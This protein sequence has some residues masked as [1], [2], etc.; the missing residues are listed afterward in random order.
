MIKNY[1]KRDV[2]ERILEWIERPEVIFIKGPRQSG[3]TTL[4]EILK[5]KLKDK[6]IYYFS[7]ED[8]N[9]LEQFEKDPVEFIEILLKKDKVFVFL[10]EYQ[11]V[12]DS[13]QK[14]KLVYDKFKE[15]AKI[16]IT[17]SNSLELEG[18]TAKYMVGRMFSLNLYPLSF[19]E[20]L[21]SKEER[22]FNLWE[23]RNKKIK[24]I[25]WGERSLELKSFST[26]PYENEMR[27]HW[28]EYCLY[29]GYPAVVNE[30]RKEVKKDILD[31][32]VQTYIN[33]DVVHLLKQ[34]DIKKFRDMVRILAGQTAQI[35]N[36]NQ[37]SNDTGSYH[38]KIK[39]FLSLLE[40]TF[41]IK[42]IYP[43]HKNL[44]T[45]LKKTPKGYFLDSG[46]RNALL[47]SYG[48]M[49]IRPDRGEIVESVTLFNIIAS[50]KREEKVSFW[51]TM[52]G[53]EVDF[54]VQKESLVYPI[55]VKYKKK[56]VSVSRSWYNFI[57]NYNP[58]SFFVLTDGFWGEKK[59]KKTNVYFVPVWYFF[60][61]G[62]F[63]KE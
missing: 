60:S 47:S 22:I 5:E 51:R 40:E 4:L 49:K 34:E 52:G 36:Y 39:H 27:R 33:K 32:L 37:L 63:E 3:K 43:Y 45:E 10:D 28:E 1:I 59:I 58:K 7:F 44:T 16:I 41:L 21:R 50:F 2:L 55:E 56:K 17:G 11:Y 31:A 12:T 23:K 57:E 53:A 42:R 61:F 29:G 18:A 48:E 54:V 38:E 8:R 15:R 25:F 19:K 35:L 13:G 14:L 24:D 20:F 30:K 9:L 62:F 46:L 6:Q 26:D